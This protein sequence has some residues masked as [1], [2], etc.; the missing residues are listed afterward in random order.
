MMQLLKKLRHLGTITPIALSL[1]MA[2]SLDH[3]VLATGGG[4]P[5]IETAKTNQKRPA[6]P[7]LIDGT[8]TGLPG[9]GVFQ[10]GPAEPIIPVK[11][12]VPFVPT[13]TPVPFLP[14]TTPEPTTPAEPIEPFPPSEPPAL[15]PNPFKVQIRRVD[16][17]NNL[18]VKRDR[19][20]DSIQSISDFDGDN[21]E[22]K[23]DTC[24][25][26]TNKNWPVA[27]KR[28][29][30]VNLELQLCVTL[31]ETASV[32]ATIRGEATG[33][34]SSLVFEKAGVELV[35]GINLVT[36]LN[37]VGTLPN[38]VTFIEPMTII[39]EVTGPVKMNAGSSTHNIFTTLDTPES[40]SSSRK[41]LYF[42]LF[43]LTTRNADGQTDESGTFA[44]IWEEF[45]DRQVRRREFNPINGQIN[46]DGALLSYYDPANKG[47]ATCS[48]TTSEELLEEE[49]GQCGAWAKLFQD[50]LAIHGIASDYH[51][52][53]S[54]DAD[55]L[56]TSRYFLIRNWRLA[57]CMP[58]S[59]DPDFPWEFTEVELAACDQ[60]GLPGQTN[61]DPTSW[62]TNHQVVIYPSGG[63]QIYDPA[64][65][66]VF[67]DRGAW[68]AAS[69]SAF[70]DGPF[71]S[72]A[73]FNA[74]C[75]GV[76][77][78]ITAPPA[79]T[80]PVTPVVPPVLLPLPVHDVSAGIQD[81]DTRGSG[82]RDL[83]SLFRAGAPAG[84]P[85]V[86]LVHVIKDSVREIDVVLEVT[87]QGNRN[88]S[89]DAT[90]SIE[91]VPN[92]CGA[93]FNANDV[94]GPLDTNYSPGEIKSVV[95]K[96]SLLCQ[97]PGLAAPGDNFVLG[98]S[99]PHPDDSSP[100]DNQDFLTF[101]VL[102][103]A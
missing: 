82:T 20:G 55:M 81:R 90:L 60:P 75:A 70:C 86:D 95:V 43:D 14:P 99:V 83:G 25:G 64:Y 6:Q 93:A 16:F 12:P 63:R 58:A 2:I 96:V 98:I 52:I 27:Y 91:Q 38:Q 84:S 41:P 47:F 69:V 31:P 92:G 97:N 59:G 35:N 61:P 94:D 78:G 68:K 49:I 32:N 10:L 103:S 77:V 45:T 22:W 9:N 42:T 76:S 40:G 57:G 5:E 79:S 71:P 67:A 36:N 8:A 50:A 15:V 7:N 56:P 44:R 4:D 29:S 89:L 33:R 65:G 62:F 53:N 101:A 100:A 1:L 72:L 13:Q 88:E 85:P 74:K 28:N 3:P 54:N 66:Q 51:F 24:N 26:S 18:E 46:H 102:T 17:T 48:F 23:D 87:N 30:Q 37:S 21:V 11:T 39:W 19:L 80:V 34:G 73:G